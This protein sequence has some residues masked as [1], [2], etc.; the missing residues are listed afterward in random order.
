M[1]SPTG[2]ALDAKDSIVIVVSGNDGIGYVDLIDENTDALLTPTPITIPGNSQPGVYGQVLFD[3]DRG[4][5]VL[6]VTDGIGCPTFRDC[7][8][9]ITFDPVARTFGALIRANYAE[10]FAY[11][12]NTQQ[13][14]DASDQNIAGMT[15][16]V[17][18]T[19]NR[20]CAL[21]D[22]NLGSDQ[23]GASFDVNTNLVVISNE[24]GTATALN[25]NG[26][27][28]SGSGLDC[29]VTEG[30]AN[31]NSVMLTGLPSETAG[32]A[33]NSTAHQGFLIEDEA[34]GITPGLDAIDAGGADNGERAV[35]HHFVTAERP[36]R[37]RMGNAGRPLCGRG[38]RNS[39][40]RLRRQCFLEFFGGRDLPG[41]GRPFEVP[42]QPVGDHEPA[43]RG[44]M[45]GN[46]EHLGLQQQ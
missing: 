38:R 40:S 44:T 42:K 46:A 36:Q 41:A 45:R 35:N 31:P 43:A 26:S 34:P 39:Q 17:D 24:D 25:L 4:I 23:D 37:L 20:T 30:G 1:G 28:L 29:T 27:T 7:T 5:A 22:S 33:V 32:S 21:S 13:V 19:G 2:T 10:T 14:L 3:P 11:N 15:Q 18:L 12:G 6:N 16:V 8:G 9:F